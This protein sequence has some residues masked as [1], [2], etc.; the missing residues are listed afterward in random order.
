M[1]QSSFIIGIG[2]KDRSSQFNYEKWIF[3]PCIVWLGVFLLGVCC[4]FHSFYDEGFNTDKYICMCVVMGTLV[5]VVIINIWVLRFIINKVKFWD[6]INNICSKCKNL[7]CI[8]KGQKI[9]YQCVIRH[10]II[11]SNIC[12][13]SRGYKQRTRNI[14]FDKLSYIRRYGVVT[15][16]TSLFLI[17]INYYQQ[18]KHIQN[19]LISYDIGSVQPSIKISQIDKHELLILEEKDMESFE[20]IA[21]LITEKIF[22]L[23]N[24]NNK[25]QE[26]KQTYLKR[27]FG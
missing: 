17:F 14:P 1:Q 20:N 21:K 12:K 25:L 8:Q 16:V 15:L 11:N 2:E 5:D 7:M 23:Y 18:M 6:N 26:L 9:K 22:N 3:V 13:S 27:F 24:V 19:D 10:R 4:G